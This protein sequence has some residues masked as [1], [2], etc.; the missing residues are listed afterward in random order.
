MTKDKIIAGIIGSI[1]VL[2]LCGMGFAFWHANNQKTDTKTAVKAKSTTNA[3]SG[4]SLLEVGDNTGIGGGINA[5]GQSQKIPANDSN[6]SSSS[7][8]ASKAKPTDFA[9]YEK[10]KDAKSALFGEIQY[11]TGA[12]A[13]A[14]KQVAISYKG[15]LTNNKVFDQ[16]KTDASGKIEPLAF[17]LGQH[18][19]IPGMEQGVLGMKVGGKRLIIIPPA[20]GYGATGKDPIP[21][22]SVLVFEVELLAVQ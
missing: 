6:S 20:A 10:Y 19:V 11:G 15:S 22:N 7:S 9:E 4:E 21:P 16:S 17:V 5:E 18:K 8:S 3:P 13:V 1:M 2:T 14:G 12:E